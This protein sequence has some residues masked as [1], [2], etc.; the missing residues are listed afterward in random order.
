MMLRGRHRGLPYSLDRAVNLP[1]D[2]VTE[3]EGKYKD[4]EDLH[5]QGPIMKKALTQ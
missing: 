1:S 3:E 2:L 5:V 4:E